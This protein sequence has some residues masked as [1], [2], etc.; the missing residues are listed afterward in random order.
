[1]SLKTTVALDVVGRTLRKIGTLEDIPSLFGS[2]NGNRDAAIRP[3]QELSLRPG[4]DLDL[5]LGSVG[6][7]F[8]PFANLL[9]SANVLVPLSD[10]GLTAKLTWLLGFDY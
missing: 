10:R 9:V 3:F 2:R 1:L 5:L 4:A 6:I 8:N 7:K